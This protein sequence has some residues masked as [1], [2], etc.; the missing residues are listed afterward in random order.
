MDV[1]FVHCVLKNLQLATRPLMIC[2]RLF[3]KKK[4]F[5][6]P[7]W[8]FLHNKKSD[9]N[10]MFLRYCTKIVIRERLA[11]TMNK[12]ETILRLIEIH[13]GILQIM[14]SWNHNEHMRVHQCQNCQ[15]NMDKHLDLSGRVSFERR[16]KVAELAAAQAKTAGFAVSAMP[17][18]TSAQFQLWHQQINICP[19][20]NLRETGL[21][22]CH[23][24][25]IRETI[26]CS[27]GA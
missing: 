18:A 1:M 15:C 4:L 11:A 23:L 13:G 20:S 14:D 7:V 27:C 17:A 22:I 3:K 9:S 8:Y 10:F 2:P 25:S 16:V 19:N 6:C 12:E 24:S 5:S 26:Y 21:N